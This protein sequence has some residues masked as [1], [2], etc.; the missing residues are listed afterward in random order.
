LSEKRALVANR[1]NYE[2]VTA[3]GAYWTKRLLIDPAEVQGIP[4]VDLYAADANKTKWDAAIKDRDAILVGGCG[5]GNPTRYTGQNQKDLLNSTNP[6]DL[7]LMRGRYGSFLSCSFGQ[8]AKK[9]VQEGGMKAFFGYTETFWFVT[10]SPP[11]ARAEP[12]FVSHYTLDYNW[13]REKDNPTAWSE[14]TKA[15]NDAIAHS[16]AYSSRY[17]IW[18]RDHRILEKSTDE[19]PYSKV[20]PPEPKYACPWSDFKSDDLDVVKQHILDIHCAV[21]PPLPERPTWCKV[22][23]DFVSCPLPKS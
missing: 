4:V 19:G 2:Q 11:D 12:F 7:A 21:C 18:D 6:A 9:F 1:C 17:L 20:V 23:G 8:A 5:H 13:I 22:F 14:S 10:S 16:D 3:I 15:W